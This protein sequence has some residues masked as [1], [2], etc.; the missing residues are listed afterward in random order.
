STG[1][2]RRRRHC[3]GRRRRAVARRRIAALLLLLLL[4]HVARLLAAAGL[5]LAGGLILTLL[6][7][8]LTDDH[9]LGH[10]LH[11]PACLQVLVHLLAVDLAGPAE[12]RRT[13]KQP[14]CY[15]A[16]AKLHADAS[17]RW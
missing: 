11:G 4:P 12:P 6:H 9:R 2:R 17:F 16:N 7:V 5:A 8:G 13:E 15:H 1:D 3:A 14:P 10:V